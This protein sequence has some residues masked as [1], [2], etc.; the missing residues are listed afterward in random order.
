MKVHIER[1]Q[2]VPEQPDLTVTSPTGDYDPLD[3]VECGPADRLGLS[4]CSYQAQYIQYG[5][6]AYRESEYLEMLQREGLIEVKEQTLDQL[7]RADQG[8]VVGVP[9]TVD[10]PVEVAP[11]PSEPQAVPEPAPSPAPTPKPMPIPEV[12][13]PAQLEIEVSA[14]VDAP[15]VSVSKLV[16]DQPMPGVQLEQ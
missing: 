12:V 8:K 13:V 10:A 16:E 6:V 9:G 7:L 15:S 5:G 1:G 3:L 4:T 14:A 2:A 11:P